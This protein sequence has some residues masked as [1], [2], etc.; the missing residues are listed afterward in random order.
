MHECDT[1]AE[2][3]RLLLSYNGDEAGRVVG[4]QL[5]LEQLQTG[6]RRFNVGQALR[7]FRR[8]RY[9]DRYSGERLVFPGMLRL[10]HH[11][12]PERIPFHPNWRYDKTHPIFWRRM[13]T[14]DHV[15]PMARGGTN[16]DGNLVTTS[17]L[18]NAAKAN[19]TLEEL[20]W[21]LRPVSGDDGWDG[22]EGIF[23][24]LMRQRPEL[25]Q[26]P[27]LRRWRRAASVTCQGEDS[28]SMASKPG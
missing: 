19:W 27:Y 4:E 23:L 15:V 21:T 12:M 9:T 25:E 6:G 2:I 11:V 17:M 20:R 5:P 24:D 7:I 22:L 28:S 1:I 18:S 14:L 16:D 8:D 10:L 3:G 13:P 26:V